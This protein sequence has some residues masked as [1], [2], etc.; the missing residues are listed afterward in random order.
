MFDKPLQQQTTQMGNNHNNASPELQELV[1]KI[2]NM[3]KQA[4]ESKLKKTWDKYNKDHNEFLD[5]E[6]SK[7][8]VS[9]LVQILFP[10]ISE[11]EIDA[12]SAQVF[13]VLD[14]NDD[15]IVTFGV[16]TIEYAYN[17]FRNFTA[18]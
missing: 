3:D 4:Y 6:E 7:E 9:H 16:C 2:A 12:T 10:K 11:A 14:S 1:K 15:G 18:S 8:L 17:I 5:A 13:D